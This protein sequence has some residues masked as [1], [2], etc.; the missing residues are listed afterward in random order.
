MCLRRSLGGLPL[1]RRPGPRIGDG[2]WPVG[3]Q[4]PGLGA[5]IE[6]TGPGAAVE[7][8]DD[9]AIRIDQRYLNNEAG[10]GARAKEREHAAGKRRGRRLVERLL[11][12]RTDERAWRRGAQGE[13]RVADA[14]SGLD[15][16]WAVVHDLTIGRRGANLD[17]LVIGPPGVFVLNTKNLTG[18]VT[19]HE[20]SVRQNGHRTTFVPG[21]A[22]EVTVVGERLSAAV[23]RPVPVSGALVLMG[24]RIEVRRPLDGIAV[25]TPP[26]V[27]QWLR[28]LPAD[29]LEPGQ[30]L[31]LERAAR[32]PHTWLP[33]G[34]AAGRKASPRRQPSSPGG[35]AA[36]ADASGRSPAS[37]S[38]V[39]V[40]R[41]RR[42]GKDRLYAN[43]PDG[44]R[45]GY[46]E[47]ATGEILLEVA[48]PTGTVAAQL[49]ASHRA[50][51]DTAA[52]PPSP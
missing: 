52:E 33:P 50:L 8:H 45:L 22:R 20:R 2:R 29:V 3:L 24:C 10:A 36:S 27:V 42:Y 31:E 46:L 9:W 7:Q 32:T 35:V 28:S 19:I 14:L 49:R 37:S 23:G 16:R 47:V 38:P 39:T 34:S 21:L 18:T 25:L 6:R 13:E 15:G 40:A 11:D 43:G 48:D 44:L 4:V 5:D 41:W 17:H 30:V 51:G 12:T 1:R 26:Q